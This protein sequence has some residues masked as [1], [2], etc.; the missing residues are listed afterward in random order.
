MQSIIILI[1]IIISVIRFRRHKNIELDFIRRECTLQR[2]D[3]VNGDTRDVFEFQKNIYFKS[4]FGTFI[5]KVS[6][7]LFTLGG[8]SPAPLNSQNT[9]V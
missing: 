9:L 3:G 2:A 1:L 7:S 8:S 6:F 5:Q 4:D